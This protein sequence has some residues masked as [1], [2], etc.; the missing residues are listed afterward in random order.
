MRTLTVFSW[1][2]W[3]WGTHTSDFVRAVDATERRRGMRPPIF[4][5]I[6]FSRSVRAP[7]FRENA[8]A[9]IVGRGRYRWLRKLGNAN[10]GTKKRVAKI[11]D[12]TGIED[13]RQFVLDA[14]RQRR[15]VIFFCSCERP[16]H[17][18]RSIVAKRLHAHAARKRTPIKVIEWPGG[19]PAS[20][21][22]A[23]SAKA[24]RNVLRNANRMP[25][26]G[27]SANTQ[28]KL[29]SLPWCSRVELH[30]DDTAFGIVSGPAQ[31]AAAGWYLP[32]IAPDFSS[33]TYSVRELKSLAGQL[34]KS[35]GYAER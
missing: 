1:G 11:A 33:E 26:G 28:R 8:F 22:L 31:L 34:R 6:R 30:S 23:V 17:C 12:P 7:G 27:V 16:C 9:E 14:H 18:H 13:L 20:I 10:I 21:K 4:V 35:L 2:Y 25:L 5:D 15:R 32:V 3:G 19:E 29:A 24:T